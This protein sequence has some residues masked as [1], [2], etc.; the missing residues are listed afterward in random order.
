MESLNID[1]DYLDDLDGRANSIAAH[2]S[3]SSGT[4]GQPRP[5]NEK[6]LRLVE[7][8]IH[9]DK[10]APSYYHNPKRHPSNIP[11]T[12]GASHL[13]RSSDWGQPT[14]KSHTSPIRTY[15]ATAR[16]SNGNDCQPDM[17]DKLKMYLNKQPKNNYGGDLLKTRS[18]CFTEEKP[19]QPRTLKY[20]NASSK[21]SQS[22]NYNPPK[23]RQPLEDGEDSDNKSQNSRGHKNEYNKTKV[24]GVPKRG[25]ITNRPETPMT[26]TGSVDWMN[27]T[28]MSRDE[29]HQRSPSGVPPLD[30]SLDAD[31]LHWLME[32]KEK[33]ELRASYS[34]LAPS[35]RGEHDGGV[36]RTAQ[37]TS[38]TTRETNRAF[39]LNGSAQAT[40]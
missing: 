6:E 38:H 31:N 25:T 10:N 21:I 15:P 40:G 12:N 35:Y 17:Y 9:D 2:P 32:Q 4:D 33:A 14:R 18:K 26:M 23:K 34:S 22:K 39:P 36:N 24:N 29:P 20:K 13:V 1:E 37:V 8:M 30:I 28:L 5:L 7:K 3:N 19:F 16:T 27:E 11:R